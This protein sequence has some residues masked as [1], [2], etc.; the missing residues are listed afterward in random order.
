MLCL[1]ICLLVLVF[2]FQVSYTAPANSDLELP[3]LNEPDVYYV[4]LSA[5][6][7]TAVGSWSSSLAPSI[8]GFMVALYSYP[9]TKRYLK[10]VRSETPKEAELFTPFQLS[11]AL[12]FLNGGGLGALWSW[13][14]YICGWRGRRQPQPSILLALSALGITVGMLRYEFPLFRYEED[15]AHIDCKS[16]EAKTNRNFGN[17]FMVVGMIWLLSSKPFHA[18]GLFLRFSFYLDFVSESCALN[19]IHTESRTFNANFSLTRSSV[20]IFAADTYLHYATRSVEFTTVS[21]L[22]AGDEINYSMV[23]S[24]ECYNGTSA[25]AQNYA[26]KQAALVTCALSIAT[27]NT[28]LL[29]GTQALSVLNNVSNSMTALTYGNSDGDYVFL[30]VP[31][32]ETLASRD[33]IA[34]TYG[35][36]AQCTPIS[37]QCHLSATEGGSTPFNCS[38]AFSGNL[39]YVTN[40]QNGFDPNWQMAFFTNESML[41]NATAFQGVDNPFY[42]ALAALVDAQESP[43]QLTSDPEIVTPVHGGLAFVLFCNTTVYDIEYTSINNSITRFTPTPSNDSVT[44]IFEGITDQAIFGSFYLQQA[45]TLAGLANSS[46]DLADQMGLSFSKAFVSGGAEV[47]QPQPAIAAQERSSFIVARVPKAPLFIVVALDFLFALLGIALTVLA[48]FS[49]CGKNEVR[50]IQSRLTITGL[51]AD[52]FEKEARIPITSIDEAFSEYEGEKGP[53]VII[54]KVASEGYGYFVTR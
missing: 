18:W 21:S 11:L 10:E 35:V 15:M 27:T 8:G 13:G 16:C 51:V 34:S 12:R 19:L 43:E 45:A 54:E 26:A 49:S 50:E 5:T 2:Y 32:T 29:D 36:Q 3:T 17:W 1:T 23:L 28:F 38:T 47:L 6:F 48:V 4:D 20:L 53:R 46:S 40:V 14:T 9:L 42:F 24:P 30:G 22:T 44:N 33:F 25:A 52:R 31:T 37:K 41:S 39:D 7:I